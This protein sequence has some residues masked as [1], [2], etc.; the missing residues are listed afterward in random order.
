MALFALFDY[1]ALVTGPKIANSINIAT[2]PN[3]ST[4]ITTAIVLPFGR[5]SLRIS[6]GMKDRIAIAMPST[7][8]TYVPIE[9]PAREPSI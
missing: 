5:F 3:A 7:T 8:E 6:A 1:P 2:E 9:P 4:A